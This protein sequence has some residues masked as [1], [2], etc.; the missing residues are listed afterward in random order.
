[1]V[2][3]RALEVHAVREDLFRQLAQQ[4]TLTE[5]KPT[6]S[7]RTRKGAPS[8]SQSSG[9]FQ[10]MIAQQMRFEVFSQ[11]LELKIEALP[12]GLAKRMIPFD[13]VSPSL[14]EK[15]TPIDHAKGKRVGFPYGR[16]AYAVVVYPVE[17]GLPGLGKLQSPKPFEIVQVVG[18]EFRRPDRPIWRPGEVPQLIEKPE[19][20]AQEFGP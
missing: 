9:V 19:V 5:S 7:V 15:P 16:S 3:G 12:E 14:P 6:M 17:H 20:P 13:V 8:E 18:P 2:H 1:M 10:E 11:P 4:E